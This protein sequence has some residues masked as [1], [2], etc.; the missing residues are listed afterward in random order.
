MDKIEK[1]KEEVEETTKEEVVETKAETKVEDTPDD[2][3]DYKSEFEKL[4]KKDFTFEKLRKENKELKEKLEGNVEDEDPDD[5]KSIIKKGFVGLRQE[6]LGDKLD[7]EIEGLTDNPYA[8]KLVKI[9]LEKYPNMS[10]KEAWA[11]TNAGKLEIQM[12]EVKKTNDSKKRKGDGSGAGD[13]GTKTT[14]PQLSSDNMTIVN[15]MGL[16]WDG[17]M[18]SKKD[19]RFALKPI[20]G[21]EVEQIKMK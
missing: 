21:G 17:S 2:D 13:K 14:A 15:R 6:L 1:D 8:Q 10:L 12:K 9:N 4:N 19:G 16:K 3:F 18:F 11:L 5:V 20:G 7:K